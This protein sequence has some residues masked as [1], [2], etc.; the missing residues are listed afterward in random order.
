MAYKTSFVL[1][2]SGHFLI[3]IIEFVG[4]Y[5]LFLRFGSIKSYTLPEVAVFYGTINCAFAISEAFG[6]GFDTF[7]RYVQ[8]GEF[9]RILLRP[10]SIIIQI[11]GAEFRLNRV[12]RFLQGVFVLLWGLYNLHIELTFQLFGLISIAI[13]GGIALFSGFFVLQATMSFFTVQ[14]LEVV[15]AFTYG[16]AQMAQYPMSIY[17]KWFRD[18]FTFIIPMSCVSYL[19]LTGALR[20]KNITIAYIAPLA[21][22]LFL[23]FSL[24]LFK[25]SVKYYCSTG[26]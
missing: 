4:V 23:G 25:K 9:D 22:F 24:L 6:R 8:R 20:N 26:S 14:S 21:G 16:G 18:I 15:N 13:L 10:C 12:G 19:P 11:L 7:H 17:K 2:S 5:A 1:L 3:T